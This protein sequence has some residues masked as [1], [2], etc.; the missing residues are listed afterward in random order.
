MMLSINAPLVLVFVVT[1]PISILFTRYRSRK[2]RPLFSKRSVKLG[3]L[4]GYAEESI[5]GHKTI[6]SY[7]QEETMNRRFQEKKRRRLR[8]LLRGGLRLRRDGPVGSTS[9]TTFRWR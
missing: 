7:H 2:V 3:E 8:R 5:S 1:V 4:N 6:K 9:S